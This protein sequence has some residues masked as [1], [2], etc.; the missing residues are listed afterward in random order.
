MPFIS[1][2]VPPKIPSYSIFLSKFSRISTILH[3]DTHQ[4]HY[5]NSTRQEKNTLKNAKTNEQT[6]LYKYIQGSKTD[7]SKSL[8]GLL[9]ISLFFDPNTI[10]VTLTNFIGVLY[11]GLLLQ[12]LYFLTVNFL[13]FRMY[14]SFSELCDHRSNLNILNGHDLGSVRLSFRGFGN[15]SPYSG[16][17][18]GCFAY[19]AGLSLCS[20]R[21]GLL[22]G[23]LLFRSLIPGKPP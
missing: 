9:N 1:T 16:I 18:W 17:L 3:F 21:F 4:Q 13:T 10:V 8:S 2:T 23:S 5:T 19:F 14:G 15:S 20:S 7:Y 6:H 11:R 22:F 12:F